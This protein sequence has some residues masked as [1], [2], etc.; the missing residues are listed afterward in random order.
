MSYGVVVPGIPDGWELVRFDR[1]GTLQRDESWLRI[2]T[3]ITQSYKMPT[4][5]I[6]RTFVVPILRR[7]KPPEPIVTWPG[8]GWSLL[9]PGWIC[10][11][12][13]GTFWAENGLNY[14][15]GYGWEADSGAFILLPITG[16]VWREDV[17]HS[18]RV[19]KVGSDASNQ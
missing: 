9:K 15:N 3:D 19:F 4:S 18:K 8:G 1:V 16:I 11:D 14:R 10:N 17:P 7:V 13:R 6:E 5:G 12:Y 2:G